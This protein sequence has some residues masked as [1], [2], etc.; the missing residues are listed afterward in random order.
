MVN[1]LVNG[2]Q[3]LFIAR[4][5]AEGGALETCLLEFA[6]QFRRSEIGADS[7][8][9]DPCGVCQSCIKI[10]KGIHP[11]V[12]LVASEVELIKRGVIEPEKSGTISTQIRNAQLDELSDLFRHR[13]YLG[14]Y[15]VVIVVDADKM[16]H[17][18][19]NRFLKTLEEPSD[20]SVIIL[21]T[22]Y[23]EAL[24]PTVRSRCQDLKFGSLSRGQLMEFLA[25]EGD[26]DSECEKAIATMAQGSFSK[27]QALREGD[28]LEI[29]DR[30]IE[31]VKKLNYG[32]LEDLLAFADENGRSREQTQDFLDQL[33]I[34]CRDMLLAKLGVSVE[35][36]FSQDKID[37]VY[38]AAEKLSPKKMLQWI[39]RIR[40][41]RGHVNLNANPRMTIESMLLEMRTT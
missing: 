16:N 35:F 27:L 11:D 8:D 29:R 28:V 14:R 33:E 32:D 4:L 22:A 31:I 6:H 21:V 19:Q 37:I 34:W 2:L 20:D 1:P 38:S 9:E 3:Y 5:H 18:A 41:A 26:C 7:V 36:L 25:K 13:P 40:R 10:D 39:D 12:R 24:L 15:K 23:P 17:H 30:V